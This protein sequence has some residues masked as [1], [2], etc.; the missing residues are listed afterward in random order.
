MTIVP[1]F[2]SLMVRILMHRVWG[3]GVEGLP[4]GVD[5]QGRRPRYGS[6]GSGSNVH[7]VVV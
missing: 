4:W 7:G 3:P 6:D 1:A 2:A 5:P